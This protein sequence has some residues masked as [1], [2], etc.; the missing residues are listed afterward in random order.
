MFKVETTIDNGFNFEHLR[1]MLQ[2]NNY[3]AGYFFKSEL[4]LHKIYGKDADGNVN[5][6]DFIGT[7]QH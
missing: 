6:T 7:L 1:D 5:W 3:R 2:Y 4:G